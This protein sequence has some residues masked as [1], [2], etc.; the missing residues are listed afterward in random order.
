M[1]RVPR[2]AR[3]DVGRLIRRPGETARI[4]GQAARRFDHGR[5][6]SVRVD[7]RGVVPVALDVAVIDSLRSW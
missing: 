3:A 7:V 4:P 2:R 5:S 6:N 1:E